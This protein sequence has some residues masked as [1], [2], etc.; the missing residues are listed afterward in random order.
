[1]FFKYSRL[2]LGQVFL[3]SIFNLRTPELAI[4]GTT[5]PSNRFLYTWALIQVC[6]QTRSDVLWKENIPKTTTLPPPNSKVFLVHF[7]LDYSLS[8]L[9]TKFLPSLPNTLN[10]HSSL[11]NTIAK[12]SWDQITHLVANSILFFLFLALTSGFFFGL[13]SNNPISWMRQETVWRETFIDFPYLSQQS[14]LIHPSITYVGW[15]G[16]LTDVF[17][18]L[19][20]S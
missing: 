20:V 19:P 1:M 7:T 8:R 16:P 3:W 12:F 11:K 17:R 9:L 6:K 2:D 4:L 14:T 10:L 18:V 13:P 15:L 5:I